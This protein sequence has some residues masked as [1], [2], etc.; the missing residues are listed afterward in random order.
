MPKVPR[1]PRVPKVKIQF[2]KWGGFQTRQ[3]NEGL[4]KKHV[5]A[6]ALGFALIL[7]VDS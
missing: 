1:M 7:W 2:L 6:G 3:I 4:T 5:C